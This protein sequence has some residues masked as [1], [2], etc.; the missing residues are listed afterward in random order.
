MDGS[1]FRNV[2]KASG[3]SEVLHA[4]K[5]GPGEQFLENLQR[6]PQMRH[7]FGNGFIST[8]RG[9]LDRQRANIDAGAGHYAP[10]PLPRAAAEIFDWFKVFLS[11]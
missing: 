4:R 9:H 3:H 6:P 5:L 7:D 10:S 1:H 8:Q 2:A 11:P